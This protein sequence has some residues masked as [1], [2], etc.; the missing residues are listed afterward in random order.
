MSKDPYFDVKAEVQRTLQDA[1][2]L[3]ESYIRIR[4]LARQDTSEELQW[5][6]DELKA[7]T[8]T[9]ASDLEELVESIQAVETVGART[10]GIDDGEL[11]QRRAF[12][13][14]VKREVREL[15]TTL[16]DQSKHAKLQVPGQTYRDEV[17]DLES[18]RASAEYEHQQQ[19]MLMH[20]QD[21]T[22][23]SIGGVVGTLKEQASIMGQEIFSQVG[24]LGELDSHVDRT[25]SRLQRATKRMN[26]F[27]RQEQNSRS[28]ICIL[29]LIIVLV[30]LLVAIIAV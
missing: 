26:D 14:T 8:A 11:D 13:E 27:I 4:K 29:I 17:D 18:G 16:S 5:A 10:F 9:L 3:K 23:D 20:E 6:K 30:I 24:L 1:Q 7:I 21:R 2:S 12:V 19:A 22:M 15:R 28:S 25:E